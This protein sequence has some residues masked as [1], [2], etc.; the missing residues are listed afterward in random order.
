MFANFI[1]S[2]FVTFLLML[3]SIPWAKKNGLLDYPTERKKHEAPTAL[4]GGFVIISVLIFMLIFSAAINPEIYKSNKIWLLTGLLFLIIVIGLI[5]DF[6]PM[7]ARN[8][9]VLESLTIVLLLILSDMT[10]TQL[11]YLT[12]SNM[13]LLGSLAGIFTWISY[14]GVMNAMNMIDGTDGVAG[15]LALIAFAFFGLFAYVQ[16][17]PI[18]LLVS[19]VMCGALLV[20]LLF[21]YRFLWNKR[22]R[23]F[24]GSAGSLSIGFLLAWSAINLSQHNELNAYPISMVYV[25]A[26]PLLD[27]CQVIVIRLRHRESP[28]KS[29]RRH[30]Q[31]KL[32]DAGLNPNQVVLIKA[33]MAILFGGIGFFGWYYQ[34]SE[35]VMFYG[36]LLILALYIFTFVEKWHVVEAF[37]TKKH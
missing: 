27:M 18:Q 31:H 26:L 24:M 29:D 23:V 15:I 16:H 37:I 12:G 3:A 11:G 34:L 36:F 17:K 6:S 20:F 21:N 10:I 35:A 8:L 32:L 4:I 19:A 9:F 1:F 13:L 5:D 25:L 33:L 14:L 30:L 7:R 22:A 2:V 28:F